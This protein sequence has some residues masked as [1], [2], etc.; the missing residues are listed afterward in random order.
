MKGIVVTQAGGQPVLDWKDVLDVTFGPD[1]VL[2]DVRATAV[3]R[4]DLL[5]ARG[6]YP[7]PPGASQI[8]GLE[9]AGVV[10]AV[11]E[12]VEGWQPGDRVCALLPG[13]GYAEQVAVPAGMLLRLPDEWSFVQGT[14]VPEVWYTAYVN[15]FLEGDLKPG[16]TVLIHAGASGVGTA[17]IQLARIT[18]ATAFVTAGRDDKLAACRDLG[19]TVAINYKEQDFLEMV[20][21]ATNG[22]GVDL[23]LDPVGG[24]YLGRNIRAL[25]PFG[26]L[27]NIGLLSGG[28]GELDLALVLRNRLHIIGSTLRNRSPAEKIQITRQFESG[29]WHLFRTGELKPVVD[30]VFPIQEAQ[31]AH[32]YVARDENIGKV[33]L[34]IT[35][36]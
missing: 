9:M 7:P 28:R 36:S 26:R 13:G 6:G 17:A 3:N 35:K 27:V 18:G 1:E 30:R 14:A 10:N 25:R 4:A 11:G 12:S 24:E 32:D 2:V 23:I 29:F 31:A 5:Q 8:L 20:L 21:A 22:Q 33:V 15:L 34:E 19:A 16:E